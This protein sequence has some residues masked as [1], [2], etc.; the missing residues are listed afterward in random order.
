MLFL[1]DYNVE[2]GS[3][4]KTEQVSVQYRMIFMGKNTMTHESLCLTC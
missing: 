1:F 4:K 2:R 3:Q